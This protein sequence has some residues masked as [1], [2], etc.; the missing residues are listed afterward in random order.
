MTLKH[1]AKS[2]K[3]LAAS[4]VQRFYHLGQQREKPTGSTQGAARDAGP[5]ISAQQIYKARQF[6]RLYSPDDLKELCALRSPAGKSLG[7]GHIYQLILMKN[8][9]DRRKLA[10]EA[11][12]QGW[13]SRELREKRL[14]RYG[15]ESKTSNAGRKP[16]LPKNQPALVQQLKDRVDT[17]TRW[18]HA[19]CHEQDDSHAALPSDRLKRALEFV[20]QT[21]EN[22]VQTAELG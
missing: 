16:R 2:R 5:D 13:S 18:V 17:W 15:T 11:A 19:L 22:A 9:S 14:Q 6:F 10:R 20:S 12:A 1:R 8:S 3:V 4:K 21:M 7:I